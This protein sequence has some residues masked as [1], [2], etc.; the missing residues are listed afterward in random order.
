MIPLFPIPLQGENSAEVESF[1]SYIHRCAFYHGVYVGELLR[2]VNRTVRQNTDKKTP[3]DWPD[4]PNYMWVPEMVRPSRTTSMLVHFLERSTHQSLKQTTFWYMDGVLGRSTDEVVETFRW[5]P[6]CIEEMTH[7]G[8]EPYFKLIWHLS[9]ITE[10]PIHGSPFLTKCPNCDQA[11][12]SYIRKQP[13]QFCSTCNQSI[14]SRQSPLNQ[15][16]IVDSWCQQGKDVVRLM[17]D[18][19]N[20]NELV[21]PIDGVRQSLQLVF[22]HYWQEDREEELYAVLGRDPL[23]ELLHTDRPI[24]LKVARRFAYCLGIS[25]HELMSGRAHQ[26]SAVMNSNWVCQLAPGFLEPKRKQPKNHLKIIRRI[27]EIRYKSKEPLPLNQIA[28]KA[29]TSVGYLE[30]RHPGLVRE[31][32]DAHRRHA[33]SE[34]QRVIQRAQLAAMR[35]FVDEK[36]RSVQ[37]SRK[38]A[39]RELREVTGLPKFVLRKA[40]QDAYMALNS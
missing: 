25:L 15:V 30:Y 19:S 28:K 33:A 9:A 1:P 17:E 7:T 24:S 23:I 8:Q 11:Q 32:V 12:D 38:Q 36:F 5:C 31:I 4:L 37:M 22:D 34:R 16:D 29:G 20:M 27:S 40:I 6:E 26:T 2:H 21:F 13:I 18:L 39:Y 10:C 14:G 35:F 3:L